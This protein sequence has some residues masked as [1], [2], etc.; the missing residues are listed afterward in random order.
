MLGRPEPNEASPY[1]FGYIDQVSGDDAVS[2]LEAQVR[3]TLPLL[4]SISE[5][6]S[7]DRYE[8]DKWSIREVLGHVNDCERLFIMRAF[9]FARGFDT[10]LPSFDQ[11]IG[12]QA[13]GADAIAWARHVD[14]F[15]LI[16]AG[17]LAFFRN[18]PEEAWLRSGIASDNRFTVRALAFLTVGHVAHHSIILQ[19]RYL[20]GHFGAVTK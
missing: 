10:P 3:E 12:V 18:L 20:R 2:L 14:E 17:T 13:A 11:H 6:K 1:Y 19:E 15:R 4:E 7:L 16:R 5:Q 8:P 9:W